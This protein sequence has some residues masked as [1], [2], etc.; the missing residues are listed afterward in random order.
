MKVNFEAGG[1][2]IDLNSIPGVIFQL[3]LGPDGTPDFSYVSEGSRFLLGLE[4]GAIVADASVLYDLLSPDHRMDLQ[5]AL[6]KAEA[7]RELSVFEMQLTLASGR[8]MWL[9]GQVRAQCQDQGSTIWNGLL[10]DIT[11]YKIHKQQLYLSEKLLRQGVRLARLGAWE[12]D[13]LSLETVWSEEVYRMHEVEPGH[14]PGCESAFD[15]YAPQARPIIREAVE[16]CLAA[17]TPFDLELP[18][19]T[20]RGRHLWVRVMGQAAWEKGQVVR[21]H[22]TF[23]DITDSKQTEEQLRVV[24]ESSTNAMILYDENGL[25]DCNA[26]TLQLMG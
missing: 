6:E 13:V 15:F 5:Q 2:G 23:Q 17:G 25:I 26:A 19:T 22:G 4:A 10:T 7:D 1:Q 8:V 21:I 12:V 9:Q 16:Q 20:A 14:Q 24:F 3:T 18:F 11:R